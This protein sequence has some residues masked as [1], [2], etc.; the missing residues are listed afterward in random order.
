MDR[1]SAT[2]FV[3]EERR[4]FE[5]LWIALMLAG[6]AYVVYLFGWLRGWNAAWEKDRP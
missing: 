5:Y 1:L 3:L 2:R 6:I 4:L